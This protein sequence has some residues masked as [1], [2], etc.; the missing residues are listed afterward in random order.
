LN[1]HGKWTHPRQAALC[2]QDALHACILT[3]IIKPAGPLHGVSCLANTVLSPGC[4]PS[5]AQTQTNEALYTPR[6]TAACASSMG[7]SA[8][9]RCTAVTTTTQPKSYPCIYAKF[10]KQVYDTFCLF[11]LQPRCVLSFNNK[12]ASPL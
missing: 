9:R 5:W 12:T 3:P 4:G 1:L 11:Y 10:K 6:T 8:C 7:R 2:G